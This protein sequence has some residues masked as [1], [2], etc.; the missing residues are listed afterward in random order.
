MRLS[1]G[2]ELED[3]EQEL[4]GRQQQ[5]A[6]LHGG[7]ERRG[8]VADEGDERLQVACVRQTLGLGQRCVK[9]LDDL[10]QV[11]LAYQ[12]LWSEKSSEKRT[13]SLGSDDEQK[14][15]EVESGIE[16]LLLGSPPLWCWERTR[17]MSAQ[18]CW[19]LEEAGVGALPST[20]HSSSVR[21]RSRWPRTEPLSHSPQLFSASGSTHACRD[22]TAEPWCQSECDF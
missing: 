4:L 20:L 16:P 21:P 7:E 15:Q 22:K 14:E 11:H 18:L 5:Q 17:L 2:G 6:V 19:H 10:L 8:H 9:L 13:Q 1:D 3:G 12:R